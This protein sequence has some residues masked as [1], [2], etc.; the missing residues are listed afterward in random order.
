[1]IRFLKWLFCTDP[2]PKTV[3]YN[4]GSP[5]AETLETQMAKKKP[6]KPKLTFTRLVR[7]VCAREQG[8][9]QINVAQ[10]STAVAHALDVLS[11][12]PAPLLV[13]TRRRAFR[14]TPWHGNSHS[15]S[16]FMLWLRKPQKH[17]K[18]VTRQECKQ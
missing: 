15:A 1:M 8:K 11:E 18:R 9:K 6:A 16:M 14:E 2:P 7:A 3:T 13:W 10:A 12:Y 17:F 4:P 5:I